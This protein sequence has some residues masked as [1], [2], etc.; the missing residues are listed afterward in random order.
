MHDSTFYKRLDYGFTVEQALL[1]PKH[2]PR[3][4]FQIEQEEGLSILEVVKREKAMGVS[5][6]D[7]AF[8]FEVKKDTLGHWLRKWRRAGEL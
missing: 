5:D 2:M 4:M 1:I 6:A 3:W 7:L 8:S